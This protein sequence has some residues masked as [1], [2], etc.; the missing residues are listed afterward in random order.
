MRGEVPCSSSKQ[1]YRQRGQRIEPVFGHTRHNRGFMR[2]HRRGR[3]AARTEWRLI[4]ATH[5]LV[6]LHGTSTGPGNDARPS[7][8]PRTPTRTDFAEVYATASRGCGGR[9]SPDGAPA[10]SAWGASALVS[11]T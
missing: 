10:Y 2:F 1:V 9:G 3:A 8:R 4:A 11:L 7:A 5:D 6:K